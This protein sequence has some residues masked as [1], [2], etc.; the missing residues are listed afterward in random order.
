M[1]GVKMPENRPRG[2]RKFVSGESTEPKKGRKI[3]G[4]SPLGG[5]GGFFG[6]SG[7]SNQTEREASGNDFNQNRRPSSSNLDDAFNNSGN[8]SSYSGGGYGGK[9]F[10]SGKR[11]GCLMPI[12]V[13]L[14]FIYLGSKFLGN[15][16]GLIGSLLGDGS[17]G[18]QQNMQQLVQTIS[19]GGSSSEWI[20]DDTSTGTLDNNVVSG[21]RDKFTKLKGNGDDTVTLMVYMCGSDLES[22]GGMA[23]MDLQEMQQAKLSDNVNIIIFTGGSRGWRNNMVSSQVNQIY[24]LS[25]KGF[26]RLMDNAGTSSMTDSKTLEAF[27]KW[28]DKNYPSTRKSLIFWDHGGGTISGYGYDEKYPRTGS[29]SLPAIDQALSNADV[30][31]DFVGF[32]ACLMATAETALMM[33]DHADYMIASEETEPGIG[34]YYTNWLTDLAGNTSAP[35]LNI[36]KRIADDFTS[37]C[38]KK[39]PGQTTTL[40]LVDLAEL[41]ATLPAKLAAFAKSTDKLIGDGDY[42][43]VATARSGSREFARSTKIDQIDLAHFA[44]LIKTKEGQE[45]AKTIVSS[46]K[47]NRTSRDAVNA[48]GLSIYFPFN[49][50]NR[51]DHITNT[52]AQIGMDTDYSSCIKHF[53]QMQVGGQA[54]SGQ[55]SIPS[56][57]GELIGGASGTPSGN[58]GTISAGDIQQLISL[59]LSG[60]GRNLSQYGIADLDE[61]NTA[62]LSS[63]PLSAD[64]IIDTISAER[65]SPSDLEWKKNAEGKPSIQMSEEKWSGVT[66]VDMGLFYDDGTGYIDL[67]LDN[68]FEFDKDNNLLPDFDNTWL[69]INGQPIAYYHT[70]TFDRGDDDYKISGR[71]PVLYNGQRADLVLVFSSDNPKGYVAGVTY[72]YKDG[73]TETVA[74][75]YSSLS[76]GDTLEFLCDYYSYKGEFSNSYTLG[77]KITVDDPAKLEIANVALKNAGEKTFACYRFTDR[78]GKILWTPVLNSK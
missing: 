43:R 5:L 48:Y 38:A 76:E 73:E 72:A 55:S 4:D 8:V 30:K 35:T 36:A 50:L 49:K 17:S 51:V 71:S 47:Y 66:S 10:S 37:V 6:N 42:S 39:C 26:E 57:L 13:L 60:G 45:L 31:F 67:G 22:N 64:Q 40:S 32:D 58:G 46:V 62:F 21:A 56:F 59:L 75:S 14:L 52:Y 65:I 78:F 20:G 9:R 61:T 41:Q 11:S 69:A 7:N 53:A 16:S 1:G 18:G 33:A 24:R 29:M 54:V 77:E 44:A 25:S 34:W 27:I 2:R 70:D 74:K 68:V 3:F 19:Q 23:T 12:L 63:E 28:T 15:G